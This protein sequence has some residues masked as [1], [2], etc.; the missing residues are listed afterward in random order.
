[1]DENEPLDHAAARELQEETSVDPKNILLTQVQDICYPHRWRS[2]AQCAAQPL[3]AMRLH[4]EVHSG[5]TLCATSSGNKTRGCSGAPAFACSWVCV[6]PSEWQ[7]QYS[8]TLPPLPRPGG[9]LWG[10]RPRPPWV[11]C[12]R[13]LC[14]P[15]ALHRGAWGEGQCRTPGMLQ[16]CCRLPVCHFVGL[17]CWQRQGACDGQHAALQSLGVWC[18]LAP[19]MLILWRGGAGSG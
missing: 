4:P 15:G 18:S 3:A 2:L 16:E 10:P 17:Q 13:G 5:R 14:S 9:H 11:V 7:T 19:P 12:E 6:V 8:C 1:M